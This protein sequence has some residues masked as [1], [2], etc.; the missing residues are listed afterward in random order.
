MTRLTI[1]LITFIIASG[2]ANYKE[3]RSLPDPKPTSEGQKIF[4]EMGCP[5]CHGHEGKG[6][7][8]LA[9]G[10]E[11]RPRNF[12][13]FKEMRGVTYQSMHTAIQDGVP[14]TGMPA[15][16]LNEEETD[17]VIAY[18]R[19]FLTDN[20]ITIKTCLNIPQIVSLA[21]IDTSGQI[22]I[23]TDKPGLVTTTLHNDAITLTPNYKPIRRVYNK[24]NSRLVRVHVKV[25]RTNE[26]KKKY[27]A[28]I[29][30]RVKDCIK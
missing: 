29:A 8:F 18:V 3:Y 26:E 25:T 14:Y 28:I 20:F 10:L 9:K 6:D 17:E 4:Q 21:K 23:E 15:F 22:N 1:I 30:L 16:S 5:M 24:K 2:F 7:G 11:P 12:T 13:S 27:L 19:S